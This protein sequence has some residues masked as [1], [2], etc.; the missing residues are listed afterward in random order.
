MAASRLKEQLDAARRETDRWP[1]WKKKEIEAEV[2]RT[3]LKTRTNFDLAAGIDR[4]PTQSS[5]TLIGNLTIAQW[6]WANE[7][8]RHS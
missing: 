7:Q 4:N 2:R 5:Q 3:P 8:Q 6:R 1:E